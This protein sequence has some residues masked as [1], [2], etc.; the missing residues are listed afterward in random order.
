V[1]SAN[2]DAIE[3]CLFDEADPHWITSTVPLAPRAG[4]VW[5]GTSP[6][7]TPGRAYGI[8]VSGPTGPGNTF[9]PSSILLD[10][11][12]RGLT[13][14][15]TNTWRSVVIDDAFDW[16]SSRKP[17]TPL[18]ATVVYEAH[19]RGITKLSKA[20]PAALRGT[21]AGLANEATIGYL[22]DLGVTAIAGSSLR[23]GRTTGATTPWPSSRRTRPTP[24]LRRSAAGPPRCS[25]SSRAW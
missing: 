10:P 11:Y 17:A 24:R 23:G 21:Y 3:L 16:G 1:W 5:E 2:A 14:V 20:V 4:G 12:T 19:V 9:N 7:L 15:T 18:D 22:K 6:L 8:R 25:A 13:R